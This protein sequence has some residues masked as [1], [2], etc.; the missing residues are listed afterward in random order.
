MGG[1]GVRRRDAERARL[2]EG[3]HNGKVTQ[4]R[5][6]RPRATLSARAVHFIYN[7]YKCCPTLLPL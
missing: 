2:S 3:T 1:W 5:R 7:V 4:R 6:P